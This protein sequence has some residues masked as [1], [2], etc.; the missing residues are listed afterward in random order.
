MS[1]FNNTTIWCIAAVQ[2]SNKREHKIN[3]NIIWSEVHKILSCSWSIVTQTSTNTTTKNNNNKNVTSLPTIRY[4]ITYYFRH[5]G[6]SAKLLFSFLNMNQSTRY[7]TQL[8]FHRNSLWRTAVHWAKVNWTIQTAVI[9]QTERLDTKRQVNRNLVYSI[10][11]YYK[12]NIFNITMN[13][14][15]HSKCW[16]WGH[17]YHA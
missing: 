5:S 7:G 4:I 12:D 14:T 16:E 11:V 2:R 15:N 3:F 8:H 9:V 1:A 13:I 6:Q 10:L 17:Q